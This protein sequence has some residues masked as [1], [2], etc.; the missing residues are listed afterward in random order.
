IADD[1][2]S[3]CHAVAN[4]WH[5]LLHYPHPKRNP[6]HH[7]SRDNSR[8]SRDGWR[9]SDNVHRGQLVWLAFEGSDAL[10]ETIDCGIQIIRIRIPL[11]Q[12]LN[13]IAEPINVGAREGGGKWNDRGV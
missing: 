10:I 3:R 9:N 11:G 1:L 13:A 6:E 7:G 12:V 8:D 2:R 4:E 5:E